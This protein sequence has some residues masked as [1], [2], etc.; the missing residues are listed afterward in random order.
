MEEDL[1]GR[2]RGRYCEKTSNQQ[3]EE[4]VCPRIKNAGACENINKML[5]VKNFREGL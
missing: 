2:R 5:M 1:E 3:K 4:V